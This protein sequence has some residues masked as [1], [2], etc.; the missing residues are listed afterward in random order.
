M[1]VNY[2]KLF[3]INY[4]FIV[5]LEVL[6]KCRIMVTNDI[7]YLYILIFSLPIAAILTFISSMF[8]KRIINKV[9]GI[10]LYTLLFFLFSAESIYFSFYKTICG[11]EA[12]VYGGQVLEFYEAILDHVK[13][14]L[15]T[16]IFYFLPY[17]F[18]ILISVKNII[19]FEQV[20]IK[21]GL[22][23]I[24]VTFIFMF[25]SLQLN[26]EDNLVKKLYFNTN[27]ILKSTNYM[28]LM[29]SISLNAVKILIKFEDKIDVVI[30]DIPGLEEPEEPTPEEKVYGENVTEIDFDAL[31]NSE[32]DKTVKNMHQYF[33]NQVVTNKNEYTG[34]FEGKNLI[35]ITAEG[36]SPIAVNEEVTPTLYKL[37][38]NGF[39]FNNFYQPI[40]NCSTSDGEF[41]NLLSILPG[42]STCSMVNT[43]KVLFPYSLG[44]IMKKYDYNTYAIHG[45]TYTYYNRDETYPN[46]GF[47]YYGYDRFNTKYK[48]ALKDIKYSWPTSD[49]DV[50]NSSYPI[51]SG[52]DKF[53]TYIMS[54]SGHLQYNFTGGNAISTKN[55]N[56]VKDMEASTAI[57]AYV[58]SQVEFD[59]SLEILLNNLERDGI[60]DDTVIVVASDHYPYGLTN[61]QIMEYDKS[62]RD[63]N[64][65][66]YK[67]TLIVYN[68][69]I[70]EPII[71]D[72]N[73]GSIDILPTLLN[74]FNVEYDSR[75]L[76]GKDIFSNANDLVIFNNKSWISD[77]GKYNSVKKKFIPFEGVEVDDNYVNGMNEIVN[78]KF[79]MSKLL[80]SKDYYRKVFGDK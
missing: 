32:K 49:I 39:V 50:M 66:L 37:A 7:G 73:V 9:I 31:I 62:V 54:I 11:V 46:L 29:P 45:W 33:K 19:G 72:K 65:D 3:I 26:I 41:V 52:D 51:Y 64:F 34:L 4:C 30:P 59:K 57:K 67:N 23:L 18:F 21:Q 12:L 15:L 1:S 2:S 48:Y 40:Y 70:E 8:K 76:I 77:K 69:T 43:G 22:A 17:L 25:S 5:I 6:F 68:S 61:K 56:V 13:L 10:I 75:L 60:L 44:K 47:T 78:L 16:L 63:T 20:K 80:I 38:N 27:D 53:V 24:F 58:A 55:K 14:N 79:Q 28:G 74:L 36:F 71:V 42:V 35:F